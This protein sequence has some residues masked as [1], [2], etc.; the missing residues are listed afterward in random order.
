MT[1]HIVEAVLKINNQIYLWVIFLSHNYSCSIFWFQPWG[2]EKEITEILQI[3][4]QCKS[5]F[6]F[7]MQ[8]SLQ[9]HFEKQMF[10]FFLLEILFKNSLL[11]HLYSSVNIFILNKF[12]WHLFY[13][14]FVFYWKIFPLKKLKMNIRN[15]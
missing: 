4:W 2:I 14:F 10:F 12:K 11:F 7:K 3:M 6:S 15:I 13:Y 1:F 9:R 5:F 8:K